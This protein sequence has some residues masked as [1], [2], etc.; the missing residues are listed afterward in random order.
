MFYGPRD[1]AVDQDG[2]LYVSDTGN[3]RIMVFGQDGN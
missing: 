1:V 2:R 3:K